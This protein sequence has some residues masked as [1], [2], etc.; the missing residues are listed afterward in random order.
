[1]SCSDLPE[2]DPD[3]DDPS[4]A[5]PGMLWKVEEKLLRLYQSVRLSEETD[6]TESKAG[7]AVTMNVTMK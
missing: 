7:G 6:V 4:I 3:P 5:T 2:P 1:M